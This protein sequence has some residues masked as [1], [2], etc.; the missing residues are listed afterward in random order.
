[1]KVFL[2]DDDALLR[3]TIKI[4]LTRERDIEIIGEANDGFNAIEKIKMYPPDLCLI[5][6]DM[7]GISG[8]E[9]IRVLREDFPQMKILLLS[10]Y[11]D[12]STIKNAFKLGADGYVLKTVNDSELVKIIRSLSNGGSIESS[13]FVNP[14]IDF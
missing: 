2:V 7:P 13:Y 11:N 14:S 10:N 12:E 3:M 6:V 1:M 5:D 4:T 8:I 9:V